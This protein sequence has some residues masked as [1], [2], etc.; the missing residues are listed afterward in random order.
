LGSPPPEPGA[1][2][3]APVDLVELGVLRGA[4]GVKGWVRVQPHSA[5][6]SVLRAC[7]KWWLLG[8][9]TRAVQ[10]TSVRRQGAILVAKLQGCETPEQA[11][12]CRGLQIGVS[13]AEF[14]PAG[15]GEVYWVDLIGARVI[16]RRGVEL[17]TVEEVLSSGAQELLQVRQGERVLLVPMV[18][19][20]V[21]EVDLGE[22]AVRVDWEVDW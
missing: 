12:R 10:A 19:R 22:R 16:N 14:P 18:D 1:A 13:R 7:R 6:A 9:R 5:Q 20:H 4:Y 8:E 17:G 15:E 2:P 21:D 3:P 11:E